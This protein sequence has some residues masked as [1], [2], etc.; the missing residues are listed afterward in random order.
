MSAFFDLFILVVIAIS[1]I[2]GWRRGFVKSIMGLAS[3]VLSYFA[4]IYF[5]PASV[6]KRSSIDESASGIS[7]KSCIVER[8]SPLGIHNSDESVSPT[9]LDS[10]PST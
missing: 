2:S 5:T 7:P 6:P 9:A 3:S 4:A 1:V 8:A 10:A